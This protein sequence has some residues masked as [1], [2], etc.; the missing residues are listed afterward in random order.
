MDSINV[1]GREKAETIS[2]HKDI[3]V[4]LLL[5]V[6]CIDIPDFAVPFLYIL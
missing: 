1:K 3:N 5:M 4:C 2:R 6:E